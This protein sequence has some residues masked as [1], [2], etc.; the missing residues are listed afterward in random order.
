MIIAVNG[1]CPG[2]GSQKAAESGCGVYFGQDH[3]KNVALR[4]AYKD[5]NMSDELEG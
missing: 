4:I 1:A 3:P 2:N 5:G